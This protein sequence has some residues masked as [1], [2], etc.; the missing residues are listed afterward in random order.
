MRK[1]LI[2]ILMLL[3][4]GTG[5]VVTDNLGWGGTA[6][7]TYLV[8]APTHSTTTIQG[9]RESIVHSSGAPAR[10]DADWRCTTTTETNVGNV[11]LLIGENTSRDN[12]EICV[13][14]WEPAI[15][16]W[17]ANSTSTSMSATTTQSDGLELLAGECWN[18]VDDYGVIWPGRIFAI[19][20]TSEA[21]AATGIGSSTVRYIEFIK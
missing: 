15:H 11:P 19:A 17:L 12:L 18:M 1:L 4:G 8:D 21:T 9:C 10:N 14:D 3:L 13:E 16:F 7:K 6:G 2:A 20:S 5:Y